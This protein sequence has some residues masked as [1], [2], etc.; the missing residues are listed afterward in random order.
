LVAAAN[1]TS[2]IR[3][4]VT[5]PPR[6]CTSLQ[7]LRELYPPVTRLGSVKV[8]QHLD[9]HC[10]RF[11]E[12]CPF[13]VLASCNEARELDVSPRGDAPGFVRVLDSRTLI[14]PDRPGNNRIDTLCN[15]L[16]CPSLS[17]LFVVPG[18]DETLRANG[19][20]YVSDDPGLLASCAVQGKLPR[21]V[22]VMNVEEAFLHCGKAFKRSNLWS[23]SHQVPRD[24]LPSLG[25][26]L[27][28]QSAGAVASSDAEQLVDESYKN[29]LY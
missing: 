28:D 5:I 9:G 3:L 19:K 21:T 17:V 24:T 26:M 25:R 22:I 20:A 11:I 10:L 1:F 14:I 6:R 13:I 16:E 23:P 4:V 29:R 2:S 18:V 15:L 8:L 27:S 7:S 12:L